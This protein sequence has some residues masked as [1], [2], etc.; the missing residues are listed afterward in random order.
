[1]FNLEAFLT[2]L[3]QDLAS[4]N[5]TLPT[6]PEVALKARDAVED[7]EVTAGQVADIVA[8]DTAISAR[9][10]Q[11]ANSPFFRAR[12]PI[13]NLQT[14][15]SRMGIATVRNLVTS[16]AMQQIFQATNAQLD[17]RLRRLWEHSVQ[18]AAICRVLAMAFPHL[19][20]EQ[21]MLA[22]LIHDVGALPI[23]VRAE[24][25]PELMDDVETLDRVIH[26]LHPQL[27]KIILSSWG[28][29]Q[30]LIDV[31]AEH[32]NLSRDPGGPVDYVDLVIVSNLQSYIGTDHPLTKADWNNIP[33]FARVG[34]EPEI[35]IVDV[36]D[37]GERIQEVQDMLL[38]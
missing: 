37:T 10:I 13:D 26:K 31:A 28:F 23:L 32:E 24:D 1:M 20:P 15:I 35:N 7:P 21:A 22:G 14:A 19:H 27:G 5:L 38:G 34:I 4:N 11:V 33:A 30:S 8:T 2:K 12:S 17:E 25:E 16:L 9:L 6:L 29:P 18:V 3:K 36:E